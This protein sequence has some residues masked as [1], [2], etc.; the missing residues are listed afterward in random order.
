MPRITVQVAR[1]RYTRVPVIDPATGEAKKI[2]VNRQR[3]RGDRPIY[4]AVMANDKDQPLP[5]R[6]CERCGNELT[7]GEK[8]KSIGI[9]RQFGGIVRYRCMACPNWQPWEYSDSLS[10]RIMQIQNETV[11]STGWEDGDAE[12]RAGEIA[13]M[14]R[15][16]ASEKQ[17]AL[18]NMPDGLRDASEYA[19]IPD[20]LESWAN[21][22]E[23]AGTEH[24]YPEAEDEDSDP[25]EEAVEEWRENAQQAIQDALDESP[26]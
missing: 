12:S 5:P 9:K 18:D 22:I 20:E 16:L 24:D 14:I 13:E 11:D 2:Q 26:L 1:Q 10:A 15:E 6:K 4:K 7:V 23:Q 8:Y 19:E 21:E 17:E 25:T 3:K